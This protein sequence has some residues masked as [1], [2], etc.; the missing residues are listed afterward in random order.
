MYD[1]TAPLSPQLTAALHRVWRAPTAGDRLRVVVR[2][3][4][5]RTRAQLD[6]WESDGGTTAPRVETE[7]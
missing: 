7:G 5:A 1:F 6:D 2:E 4:S 3:T